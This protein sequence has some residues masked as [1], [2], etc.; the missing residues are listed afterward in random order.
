MGVLLAPYGAGGAAL[1]IPLSLY[2]DFALK[3]A[4]VLAE[5]PNTALHVLTLSYN[6]LE[7]K[8][9]LRL[10]GPISS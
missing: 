5:N 7:D 8:G 3:L 6:P 1:T 10:P 9:E 2:S 4:C